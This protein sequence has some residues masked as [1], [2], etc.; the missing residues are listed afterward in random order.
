[1]CKHHQLQ[2]YLGNESKNTLCHHLPKVPDCRESE[3]VP[4]L[5]VCLTVSAMKLVD[6]RIL[7]LAIKVGC[8]LCLR[9]FSTT[10][11]R[12]CPSAARKMYMST[13]Q[14]PKSSYQAA[15]EVLPSAAQILSL[16]VSPQVAQA[17]TEDI[18]STKY[19]RGLLNLPNTLTDDF[20]YPPFLI[21]R[22]NASM[23]FRGA[24]FTNLIAIETLAQNDNLPGFSKYSVIFAPDMGKDI[25]NTTLRWA[26][27]D[28]HPREDHP[29]NMRSLITAFL[30]DATVESAAYSFQ[31]A[32]DWLHSPANRWT[33]KYH[34]I[35][36]EGSVELFT[37]KRELEVFAGTAESSEFIRQ[38]SHPMISH[39]AA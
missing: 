30:P 39:K 21:G 10:Y 37:V 34:D 14:S 26:Q 22:W 20:W 7:I 24:N 3:T 28:S 12:K 15:R 9:P 38:V 11:R 36:G 19:Q 33:I 29:F 8:I 35:T 16:I 32:P 4:A 25:S 2:N 23:K 5:L 31:K 1:M 13:P 18:T 27:I 17:L 6:K